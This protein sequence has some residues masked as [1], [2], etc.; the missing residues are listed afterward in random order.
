MIRITQERLKQLSSTGDSQLS[1]DQLS[2]IESL[3]NPQV[4]VVVCQGGAVTGKTYTAMLTACITVQAGLLANVKQ[5]KTLVSTGE[6]G[7]DTKKVRCPTN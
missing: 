1:K 6:W 4:T 7:L 2:Y 5:T 3:T